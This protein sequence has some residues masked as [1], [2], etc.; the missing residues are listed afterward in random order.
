MLKEIWKPEAKESEEEEVLGVAVLVDDEMRSVIESLGPINPGTK[1]YTLAVRNLKT[2]S[3]VQSQY[4]KTLT[5]TEPAPKINWDSFLPKLLSI[6]VY[7][8]VTI[9]F[10]AM[11]RENPTAM[12]LVNAANTLLNPRV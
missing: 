7:G 5:D 10:I 8:I 2:L 6:S 3:E 12:R 4:V 9:G 1:E 11:E